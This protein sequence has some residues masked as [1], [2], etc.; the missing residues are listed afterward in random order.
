M[1]VLL[2]CAHAH[3]V[4]AA[5][6]G[7]SSAFGACLLS[8]MAFLLPSWRV[9]MAGTALVAFASLCLVV[10][11]IPESPRWLLAMGR[12]AS[13]LSGVFPSAWGLARIFKLHLGVC[14]RMGRHG[15]CYTR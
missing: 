11:S 15:A 14:D 5:C 12:K 13:A 8:L 1:N 3:P 4:C 7:Y 2:Q 10:P 9:L 6:S